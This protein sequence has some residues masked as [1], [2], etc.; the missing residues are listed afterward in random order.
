MPHVKSTSKTQ[1]TLHVCGNVAS[2]VLSWQ[3]LCNKIIKCITDQTTA[4]HN[5]H[6]SLSD[7]SS[8]MLQWSKEGQ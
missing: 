4:R 7:I 6:P 8:R 1:C 5:Y 3:Q 2:G